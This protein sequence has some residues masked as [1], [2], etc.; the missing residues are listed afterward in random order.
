M[1]TKRHC[2]FFHGGAGTAGDLSCD[3]GSLLWR[4]RP[5]TPNI[6]DLVTEDHMESWFERVEA[7]SLPVGRLR[8]AVLHWVP[9]T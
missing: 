4:L 8:D 6:R 7:A 2:S 9:L 5:R 1:V 3:R